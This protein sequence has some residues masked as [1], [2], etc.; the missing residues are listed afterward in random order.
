LQYFAAG[1]LLNTMSTLYALEG[2]L[3]SV[4]LRGKYVIYADSI[5]ICISDLNLI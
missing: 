1:L 4:Q 2:E 5:H 3:P